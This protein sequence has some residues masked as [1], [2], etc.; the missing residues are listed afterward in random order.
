MYERLRLLTLPALR[1]SLS[2]HQ[3]LPRL[4]P[5]LSELRIGGAADIR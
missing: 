4:F 1:A 2:P 5:R 3:I